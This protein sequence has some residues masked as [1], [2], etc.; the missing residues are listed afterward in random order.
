M[1]D[2]LHVAVLVCP[3]LVPQ[4]QR[5][6]DAIADELDTL[7]SAGNR[8]PSRRP[9]VSPPADIPRISIGRTDPRGARRRGAS[10]RVRNGSP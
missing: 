7:E 4:P 2:E 1:A 8:A 3:S 5:V 10:H 6:A 9:A